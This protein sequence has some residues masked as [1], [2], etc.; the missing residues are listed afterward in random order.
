MEATEN[1]LE[2]KSGDNEVPKNTVEPAKVLIAS[3]T[4]KTKDKNG[5]TMTTPLAEVHCK[6]PDK[7][8]IIKITKIKYLEGDKAVVRGFWVQTDDDGKFYK[9]STI[10][11]LLKKLGVETLADTYGK[12]IDTVEESKDSPYLCLKAY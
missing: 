9:G 8:D 5:K 10:D 2:A 1:I 3:V 7:D 11:L 6:H 4:I 12:E